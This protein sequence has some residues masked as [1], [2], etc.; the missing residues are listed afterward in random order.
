MKK[1]Y[2]ALILLLLL[3]FFAPKID[4]TQIAREQG[5]GEYSFVVSGHIQSQEFTSSY[6]NGDTT[7]LT[8]PAYL[9]K[10]K[11]QTIKA[12]I[13]G[14]RYSFLGVESDALLL[15]DELEAKVVKKSV[16]DDI[17]IYYL[18]SGNLN[19]KSIELFGQKVNMQI[20]LT[21]GKVE[22]GIPVLLGSY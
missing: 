22:V 18:W 14:E 13:L 11:K 4:L 12:E 1:Y 21:K 5:V 20:A 2:I 15:I 8:C 7:I 6:K 3:N 16:V 10:S 19:S 17:T 9:A